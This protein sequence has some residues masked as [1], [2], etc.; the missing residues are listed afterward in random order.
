MK[1]NIKEIE[2]GEPVKHVSSKF[3]VTTSNKVLTWRTSLE[4]IE[5]PDEE[6]NKDESQGI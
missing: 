5:E 2:V 4:Q 3:A 6:E 1:L